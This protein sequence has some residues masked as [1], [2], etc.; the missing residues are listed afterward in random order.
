MLSAVIASFIESE[1]DWG[2][3]HP[4]PA[5]QPDLLAGWQTCMDAPTMLLLFAL[6]YP[7]HQL[8]L[9][10]AIVETWIT[11]PEF[12]DERANQ[13]RCGEGQLHNGQDR[14]RLLFLAQLTRRVLSK[15]PSNL[16]NEVQHS[17]CESLRA[18][19]PSPFTVAEAIVA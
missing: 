16:R 13:L 12:R 19:F 3:V 4:L 10:R 14:H 17:L 7:G 5:S 15:L 11:Q 1:P 6:L 8:A 18:R 2:V 9:C